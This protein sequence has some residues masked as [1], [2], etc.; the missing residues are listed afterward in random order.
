MFHSL[1]IERH[2]FGSVGFTNLYNFNDSDLETS[3]LILRNFL[4]FY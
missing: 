3:I 4:D 2:R 1:I